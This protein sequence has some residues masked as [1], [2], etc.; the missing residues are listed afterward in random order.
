MGKEAKK[1]PSDEIYEGIDL[2]SP[3]PED[4]EER[5]RV[6]DEW[7]EK[8]DQARDSFLTGEKL[9]DYL[10]DSDA[11]R[12]PGG[13]MK[14]GQQGEWFGPGYTAFCPSC[15]SHWTSRW[16]E[17]PAGVKTP[18]GGDFEEWDAEMGRGPQTKIFGP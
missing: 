6:F 14:C 9:D 7:R 12:A 16:E 13:C 8:R 1:Y 17:F 5:R 3:A 11:Y 10:N 2:P 18:E 4:P 15:R